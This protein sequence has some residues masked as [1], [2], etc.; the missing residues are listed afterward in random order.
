MHWRVAWCTGSDVAPERALIR[1]LP[2]AFYFCDSCVKGKLRVKNA[3]EQSSCM[4]QWI[5]RS[6]G[7]RRVRVR[8]LAR[9]LFVH[10]FPALAR[11]FA[12]LAT[13]LADAGFEPPCGEQSVVSPARV[14]SWRDQVLVLSGEKGGGIQV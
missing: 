12:Q 9:A 4:V 14:F 11:E 7:S 5:Q 3:R 6:P 13:G 10:T 1:A 8:T 2:F